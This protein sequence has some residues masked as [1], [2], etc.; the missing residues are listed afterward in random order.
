MR[1]SVATPFS[2]GPWRAE[3]LVVSTVVPRLSRLVYWQRCRVTRDGEKCDF[4]QA[5]LTLL[6][7][8]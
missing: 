5:A 1:G 6:A 4:P 8:S 2:S 7:L 3:R